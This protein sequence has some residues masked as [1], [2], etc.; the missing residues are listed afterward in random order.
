MDILWNGVPY[1]GYARGGC[2]AFGGYGVASNGAHEH[3]R[4][5]LLDRMRVREVDRAAR[6]PPVLVGRFAFLGEVLVGVARQDALRGDQ[7][8]VLAR[9]ER[10]R[11]VRL[12]RQLVFGARDGLDEPS[13][14]C[15]RTAVPLSSSE[16]PTIRTLAAFRRSAERIWDFILFSSA[17]TAA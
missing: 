13:D 2:N 7:D 9:H 17:S 3:R 10:V 11:D 16:S 5:Y 12:D 4:A 15:L 6:Q 14:I 8:L 1:R